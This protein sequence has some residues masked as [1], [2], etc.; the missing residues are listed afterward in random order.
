MARRG[1]PRDPAINTAILDAAREL[2]REVGYAGL[3]MDAVA[4][5]AHVTK[6]TVYLR[7]PSKGALVFEVLL[8][9]TK[10][11]KDPD[12][13]D[14]RTDLYSAYQAGV[15]EVAA[16]EARAALP[17]LLA[18][19]STSPELARLVQSRVLG[20]EYQRV[21]T[22]LEQAQDRGEIRTDVDLR[23]IIDAFFGTALARAI[24]LGGPLD[25]RFSTELVDLL[26]GGMAPRE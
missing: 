14:L 3:T 13:G 20:P 25:H 17:I 22:L 21:R 12:S 16:P 26:I 23:L 10:A 8:G 9:K 1:K 4:A 24:L 15:D 6:P 7:Y 11:L 5:R 19:L 18:E 2:L